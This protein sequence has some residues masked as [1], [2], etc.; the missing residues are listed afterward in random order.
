ML[1]AFAKKK[2][3]PPTDSPAPP[4]PSPEMRPE[5]NPEPSYVEPPSPAVS[6]Q[7][8]D[9]D[10]MNSQKN[11]SKKNDRD[12]MDAQKSASKKNNSVTQRNSRK[13]NIFQ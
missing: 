6:L 1:M 4:M 3:N 7:P 8:S 11:P 9:F 10:F 5:T 12:F 2:E 13:K